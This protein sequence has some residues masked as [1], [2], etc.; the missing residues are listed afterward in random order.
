MKNCYYFSY[1]VIIRVEH[2]DL[3]FEWA[4]TVSIMVSLFEPFSRDSLNSHSEE[5][6]DDAVVKE[7]EKPF[8]FIGEIDDIHSMSHSQLSIN[9]EMSTITKLVILFV[10]HI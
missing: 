10:F 1:S 2:V 9:M 7:E 6:A 4:F 5:N 8:P 3:L